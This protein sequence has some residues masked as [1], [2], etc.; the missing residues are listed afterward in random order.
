MIK[1]V[2]TG[3]PCVGKTTLIRELRNLGYK[4]IEESAREIIKQELENNSNCLPWKKPLEFQEKVIRKQREI[5]SVTK[6]T[7]FLD[8]SL[9]DSVSYL[10][11]NKCEIPAYIYNLIENAG[12]KKAFYLSPLVSYLADGERQEN[13]EQARQIHEVNFKTYQEFQE[14]LGIDLIEVPLMPVEER[15]KFILSKL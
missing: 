9:I 15:L 11:C 1:I 14:T 10:I 4:T 12:Y 6:G 7:V 13:S 3:G 5:E 2:L 8:R